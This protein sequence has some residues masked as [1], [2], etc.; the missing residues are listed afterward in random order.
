MWLMPLA[1]IS[2]TRAAYK[3]PCGTTISKS[4]YQLSVFIAE[5]K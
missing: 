5:K 2:F 4:G 1:R 3:E